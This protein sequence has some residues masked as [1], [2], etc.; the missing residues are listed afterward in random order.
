MDIAN[1]IVTPNE[2]K[3]LENVSHSEGVFLDVLMNNAGDA[4]AKNIID[5]TKSRNDSILILCG[6][7]NNGGDGFVCAA[8][9]YK[10]GYDIKICLV[11]KEPK[12]ILAKN[13]LE[14]VPKEI[15]CEY[16]NELVES[17][18]IIVD[19][20][21][22]TGFHR[23]LPE[24]IQNMFRFIN[25]LDIVKIA[26]DIPS[27]IDGFNGFASD[28]TL[29]CDYT[30]CF[31]AL[32]SGMTL[33]P[34]IKICGEIIVSDIGI[35][36]YTYKKIRTS[37]YR[38]NE[39]TFKEIVPT[40]PYNSHKGDFGKLLIVGG[41]KKLPGAAGLATMSALRSGVGICTL[42]STEYVTQIVSSHFLEPTFL[43]L[44]STS[45]GE[46]DY[47]E[48]DKILSFSGNYT[49]ILIGCGLGNSDNTKKLVKEIVSKIKI[50]IIL[51]AD[52]INVMSDCISILKN[53]E[54]D[55]ILT[56]HPAEMAR[57]L[58]ISTA[59]LLQKRLYYSNELSQRCNSIIVSKS[60][61]TIVTSPNGNSFIS[62]YGNAGLS[63]GGSGDVLAGIISSFTSQ[64]IDA[65]N[66]ALAGVFI[67]GFTGDFVEKQTSMLGMLPSDI[68]KN[69]PLVFKL[70]D[71]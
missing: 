42:A 54:A 49:A 40:R 24:D 66:S 71:R 38:I 6:N 33:F 63:R 29:K 19:C 47:K 57:L 25:S 30:I 17:S 50:P 18:D 36:E 20:I 7:G 46:I 67:H 5:I 65:I 1:F 35:P 37:V 34:A 8:I 15:I 55:I 68:I 10:M 11:C 43:P 58:N 61:D 31:G 48:A 64:K 52:G 39:N 56:P 4:L 3:N 53:T 22:G 2:M 13:A 28:N 59:E 27:G 12:T 45:S 51:D 21:F 26:C 41:S 44:N 32:K 60:C 16:H 23:K 14:N 70:L 69:L 9:L 62:N